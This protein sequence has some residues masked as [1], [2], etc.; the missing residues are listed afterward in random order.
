MR[1][2]AG[3]AKGRRLK[4]PPGDSTRP[5][6][7]RVK[8]ALFSMLQPILPGARVLD[9]YA[10]SGA[11]GIEALSR[12]ADHV[13][14]VE[15]SRR[16][17]AVLQD[18]LEV[19]GFAQRAEVVTDDVGHVLDRL[20][21]VPFDLVLMDPPYA[22]SLDELAGVLERVVRHL[23]KGATVTVEVG[24]HDDEL[25]WPDHL[26]A[27]RER[28]YGDTVLHTATYRDVSDDVSGGGSHDE[29]TDDDL[30]DEGDDA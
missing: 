27:T 8:E 9:L 29:L 21:A 30:T 11:L 2:I 10:G 4:S 6:A 16:A 19:T 25:E 23:A 1:V 18:N 15:R 3:A 17:V 5:T 24:R 28:R 22:T 26:E 12:G 7:D 13:T 14:F 20:Q